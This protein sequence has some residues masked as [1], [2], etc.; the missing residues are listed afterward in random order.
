MRRIKRAAENKLELQ[1]KTCLWKSK[2]NEPKL[3][4]IIRLQYIREKEANEDED[5]DEAEKTQKKKLTTEIATA[6]WVH[7]V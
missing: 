2:G 6:L 1:I 4:I 5:E 7:E 3:N